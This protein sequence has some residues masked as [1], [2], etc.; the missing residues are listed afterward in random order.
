[1]F[2][3]HQALVERVVATLDM[4]RDNFDLDILVPQLESELECTIDGASSS[5]C[6]VSDSRSSRV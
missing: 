1:M 3:F 5:G 6:S 2:L 4:P